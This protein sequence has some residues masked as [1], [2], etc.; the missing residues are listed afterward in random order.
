MAK[1]TSKPPTTAAIT[2][3]TIIIVEAECSC[4]RFGLGLGS[5][6]GVCVGLL[7]AVGL[8]EGEDERLDG[9]VAVGS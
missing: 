1:Q 4:V 8:T 9:G 2:K 5:R 3:P 6:V 7:E